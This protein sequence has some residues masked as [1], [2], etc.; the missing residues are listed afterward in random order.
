MT[1]P[2]NFKVGE[3]NPS[4]LLY[5]FGVG[6]IVDLPHLSVIVSGLDDWP[7]DPNYVREIQEDRLLSAIQNELGHQVKRLLSLPIVADMGENTNLFEREA[8]IGV[9][10]ATF[11]QWMVC[12]ACHLLGPL[13]SELFQ[14]EVDYFHPDRT[15]YEHVNCQYSRKKPTVLPARF[16]VACENGHL[17]DF[18]WVEY[19]HDFD[20]SK[21]D[22]KSL[23]FYEYE[24]SGEARDL[25]VECN[26]CHAKR[27]LSN[28]FGQENR[29]KMPLCKGRRPHLH[30]YD[31]NGCDEEM[32][33]RAI[34]L[35]ASNIWFPLV[36]NTIALP[37]T[38]E[39]LDNLVSE[40][41]GTLEKV[42]KQH[43]LDTMEKFGLLKQFAEFS[44]D[45]LWSAVQRKHHTEQTAQNS[46]HPDLFQPEWTVLREAD[47]QHQ[48]PDFRL[49][50]VSPPEK[51]KDSD[52]PRCSGRAYA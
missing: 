2:N 37:A 46:D 40:N 19:V 30:D 38:I 25:Y 31:P 39:K 14:L 42:N 26:V 4:Q 36:M 20:E 1:P 23:T 48:T 16:L 35:G 52:L 47:S 33:V 51:Y 9:P 17:D 21:Y 49:R 43:E 15:H 12:P 5:S 41:W 7:V 32:H 10:V 28:A 8:H 13:Q 50:P 3:L 22:H 24:P 27:Q 45:E 29:K 11:P 34:L 6:A 18:P 44:L